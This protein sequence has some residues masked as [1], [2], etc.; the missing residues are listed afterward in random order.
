VTAKARIL[1]FTGQGKGKTTAAV[2]MAIRAAGHDMRVLMI[3]FVKADATTGEVAAFKKLDGIELRQ[4]GLGFIPKPDSPKFARHVEAA[5][6][7]L[8]EARQEIQDGAADLVIL[9]E[10]CLAVGEGLLAEEDVLALLDG[11]PPELCVVL[12]GQKATEAIIAAADTVT[13]MKCIKHG[14]EDGIDAQKG[15][16]C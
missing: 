10:I 3:Q 16:E 4:R 7:A 12:T 13:E 8:A 6:A 1:I 9:D 14:F 2:G 11:V 15:V 5:Q